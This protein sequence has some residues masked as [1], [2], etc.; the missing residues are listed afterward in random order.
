MLVVEAVRVFAILF[1]IEGM[2]ARGYAAFVNLVTSRGRLD[3]CI[4]SQLCGLEVMIE[5]QLT[6]P[7]VDFKVSTASKLPVADLEG[8][9]HLVIFV[10]R[11]VEAFALVSLH[12][13]VVRCRK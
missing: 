3:L 8:D 12:L 2:V 9:R 6:H 10:E 5:T 13:D 1:R 4:A 7:E 11:F